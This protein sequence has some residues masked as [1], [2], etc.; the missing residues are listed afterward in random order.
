MKFEIFVSYLF[1]F[2]INLLLII[3]IIIDYN[4]FDNNHN[5]N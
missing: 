5:Y 3:I 2:I 1:F 4:G